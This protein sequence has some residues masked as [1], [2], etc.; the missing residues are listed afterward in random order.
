MTHNIHTLLYIM[1]VHTHTH[2][3]THSHS[4]RT[5]THT[6]THTHSNQHV[7]VEPLNYGHQGTCDAEVSAI[8]GGFRYT[9]VATYSEIGND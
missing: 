7:T 6:H 4:D 2:E 9:E 3:H 1:T 5:H 8:Q